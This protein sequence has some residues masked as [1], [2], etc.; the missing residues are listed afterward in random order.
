MGGGGGQ[1]G[2]GFKM[3]STW[4]SLEELKFVE[5]KYFLLYTY[6]KINEVCKFFSGGVGEWG[7]WAH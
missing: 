3:E 6:T 4:Q 5:E 1:W 7:Y 2:R